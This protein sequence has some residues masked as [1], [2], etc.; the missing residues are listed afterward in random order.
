MA[1]ELVHV[2]KTCRCCGSPAVELSIPL[3]RVPIVSPNVD[4]TDKSVTTTMAPLDTYLCRDCGLI[5]LVHVVDPALIYRNYLYRTAI[6]KGLAEHFAGLCETAVTRLGLAAGSLV[7]EFGSNDGTLLGFFRDRGLR[8]QG[9]D[10]AATIAQEATARGIPTRVDFFG[11]RLADQLARSIGQ[12]DL[13][14]SNNVM[15]NID[16]LDDVI[17][18]IKRLM[19]RDGAYAFETQYALDVF[20]HMLLDVIYHEHISCFSVRPVKAAFERFGLE[21]FD[22][23]RIPTKGGSIRFWI[24]HRGAPRPV[25]PRVGE[26]IALEQ[27]AG[28]YDPARHRRFSEKVRDIKTRLHVI[29]AEARETGRPIAA[30]GTSVGCAALIH[31]FE[32]E[33]KLDFML[34]DSPFKDRIEGPGYDLPVHTAEAVYR[35]DPALIVILAWRYAKPIVAGHRKYLAAGGR[36]LVPLPDIELIT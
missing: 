20:E 19:K 13:I 10:P 14:L 29:I 30:Y 16:D 35:R 26:L 8:V 4:V 6:S 28:L 36:F 15:A 9:I 18:G 27:A 33:D 23:E 3:A 5:Q 25:S 34:D 7:V 12:A 2:R 1:T 21:L 24:Q 22:A 11:E 17:G 32:L 31:Q